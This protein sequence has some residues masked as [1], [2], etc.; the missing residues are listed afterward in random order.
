MSA[1][2]C[3][4]GVGYEFSNGRSLF[5]NL[6]LSLEAGLSALVGPNGVGKTYLA[7]ILA[8]DLEPTEGTVRRKGSVTLFPQRQEAEPV[9]VAEFLS[10]AYEWSL[11]KEVLLQSVDREAI[12]TTLSGGQWTRVRLARTLDN[13]FLILDEPTNDLDRDGREALVQFLRHREGGALLISHDRE[14]LQICGEIL[15]LSNRGLSKF[16][17]DWSE[18]MEARERE[19]KCL[20]TALALA[21][22]DREAALADRTAQLTRQESRNRRG[23]KSAARGGLP[24]ILFGARKRRAQTATGRLNAASQDRVEKAVREA[25]VALS[26]IKTDP[27]MYADVIGV[28]LPAQKL[29]AE[30]RGFNVRFSDWVYRHDLEF[31]WRG[32]V[33]VVLRGANGSGKSTLL[34]AIRGEHFEARGQLRRGGLVTL[35]IDQRCSLLDESKSVF[36]NVRVLSAAN[37]SQVRSGLAK[38]LFVR[39][40]VFQRVSELSGGERLRAALARGFLCTQKPELL[41]LDEPTNNLDLTNVDF[42]AGIVRGFRGAVIVVSHDE[43]FLENCGIRREVVV[44]KHSPLSIGSGH[45]ARNSIKLSGSERESF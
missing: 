42:L 26:E 40:S 36:D 28:E 13:Q 18:Y 30:A 3:A 43:R 16:G 14:C 23:T 25:H 45:T 41:L 33:R 11:L 17:G 38:F 24:K 7:R 35:Y 22:R 39:E 37:D 21:K 4:R 8:G 27:V 1:I 31:M 15:E 32:S 34:R 19:R 12:C 44:H 10:A 6:N 20:E 9:T 5:S 29:V 2:V